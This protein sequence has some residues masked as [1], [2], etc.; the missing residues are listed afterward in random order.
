MRSQQTFV[1]SMN[2]PT[3]D[4]SPEGNKH[5]SA[6]TLFPSWEGLGVGSWSQCMRKSRRRL[7]MN[8]KVG[9]A[10]TLRST[11]TEDGSCL[12]PPATPTERNR[13]RW[14]ARRTGG[15]P[16]LR[17]ARSGSR[18]HRGVLWT[19][20]IRMTGIGWLAALWLGVSACIYAHQGSS[21]YL[22]IAID[23]VGVTGQWDISLIDLD[24][25]I[26][27][28]ADRN[29]DITWSEVKRKQR[30]IEGYAQSRLRVKLDGL[31]TPWRVTEMS[32]D[33]FSDG[34]YAI[35][36]LKVDRATPV[37]DLEVDYRAFFDIDA[38]HRGFFRLQGAGAEQTWVF[39]PDKPVFVLERRSRWR[40]FLEFNREGVSHIWTGFDHMLFLLALLL[41]SVL[42]R[43][44]QGWRVVERFRPALINVLKIV[45]AFTL[46]HSITLSLAT[47]GVVRV[48]ARL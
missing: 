25:V 26:G 28:D 11:A 12:P 22:S 46:A 1:L 35:L 41:P 6:S 29:G 36:R 2:R 18:A 30:E 34:T 9:R 24:Q 33:T 48:P 39:S 21:S 17:W 13:S 27:V 15:T 8:R 38:F 3:P 14:R 44:E 19:R 42:K 31:D 23:G 45:T 40:Q 20:A 16:A 32:I 7:S 4:P 10:S 47:L 43:E 37:K 5:S